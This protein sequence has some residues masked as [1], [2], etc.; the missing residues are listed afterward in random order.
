V[1]LKSKINVG[2]KSKINVGLKSKINVEDC[3]GPRPVRGNIIY[4]SA[5]A[6]GEQAAQIAWYNEKI[7]MQ[8]KHK[9]SK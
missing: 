3:H 6:L 8:K 2:W 4:P 9:T 5:S 7:K 1:G